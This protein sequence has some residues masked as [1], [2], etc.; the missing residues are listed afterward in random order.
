M[1]LTELPDHALAIRPA[2][3]SLEQL[4]YRLRTGT[5]AVMGRLQDERFLVNLRAVSDA[6]MEDLTAALQSVLA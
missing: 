6:Q 1:P 2:H 3:L 5:P 4:A